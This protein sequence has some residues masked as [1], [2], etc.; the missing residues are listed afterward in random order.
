[1]S[2]RRTR[3]PARKPLTQAERRA[4]TIRKLTHATLESLLEVGYARTTVKEICRRAKLSDGALFRFFPK[5]LDLIL[6]AAEEVARMQ[7]AEFEKRFAAANDGGNALVTAVSVLRDICRSETNMM[8]N[9]LLVAART[10]AAL[11]KRL[12]P[13]ILAYQDAIRS[14]SDRVPGMD[15][16]PAELREALIFGATHLFDREA[17]LRNICPQT[18]AEE[19][20]LQLLQR[21]VATLGH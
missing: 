6:A 3:K 16:I 17:L 21:L 11:R 14:A 1:V 15:A 9:E 19:L 13:G 4:T 2:I 7:I 5:V 20:R 18:E 12:V 8:F 10:D